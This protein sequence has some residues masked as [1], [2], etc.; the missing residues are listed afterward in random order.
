MKKAIDIFQETFA[1]KNLVFLT[2]MKSQCRLKIIDHLSKFVTFDRLL[3]KLACNSL[4]I[5]YFI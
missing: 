3:F 5:K 1:S 4:E 2:E